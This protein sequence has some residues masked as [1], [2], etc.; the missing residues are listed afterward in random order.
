[1]PA[2][3]AP[4]AMSM[5]APAPAPPPMYPDFP[6]GGSPIQSVDDT[7]DED[8][9]NLGVVPVVTKKVGTLHRCRFVAGK[10]VGKTP[11]VT[12]GSVVKKRQALAFIEQL[13]TYTAVEVRLR[14]HMHAL[15]SHTLCT[16]SCVALAC[17]VVA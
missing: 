3:A 1:M 6:M 11:L 13:G 15:L 7:T 4:P 10:Q 2:P 12:Q 17:G 5:P 14:L 8:A 9:V 16:S